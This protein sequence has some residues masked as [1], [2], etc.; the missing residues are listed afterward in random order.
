V[1]LWRVWWQAFK[2]SM[3]DKVSGVS[4]DMINMLAGQ[5]LVRDSRD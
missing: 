1:S 2:A 5:Q 4:D 3:G